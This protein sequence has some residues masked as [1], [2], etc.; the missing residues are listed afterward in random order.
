[1]TLDTFAP[2][3]T[4]LL[5]CIL[6]LLAW[7]I[8]TLQTLPGHIAAIREHLEEMDRDGAPVPVR[9]VAPATDRADLTPFPTLER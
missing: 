1:M 9:V 7:L 5:L 2:I 8:I 6:F 4:L 3:A